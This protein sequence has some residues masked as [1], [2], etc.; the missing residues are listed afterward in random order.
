MQDI[1]KVLCWIFAGMAVLYLLTPFWII[2]HTIRRPYA[3]PTLSNLLITELLSMAVSI[4]SGMA[5][6]TTLKGKPT[7]RAWGIAASLTYILIFLG[8]IAFSLRSGWPH[9]VGALLIGTVGLVVFSRRDDQHHSSEIP[10]ESAE[11]GP[12]SPRL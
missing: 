11:S 4:I 9:H 12:A 7:K 10:N 8:P 6:W 5:W 3:L 2:L 1:R